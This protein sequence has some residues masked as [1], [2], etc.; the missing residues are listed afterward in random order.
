MLSNFTKW[1]I[2]NQEQS[3][4]FEQNFLCSNFP[5]WFYHHWQ[6]VLTMT[7]WRVGI[8]GLAKIFCWS[9]IIVSCAS[10]FLLEHIRANIFT[11]EHLLQ[12]WSFHNLK[13][14][15]LE[16][17]GLRYCNVQHKLSLSRL[18]NGAVIPL[19]L[20]LFLICHV[21]VMLEHPSGI[22]PG[23]P[24]VI[25]DPSLSHPVF[26]IFS[27]LYNPFTAKP[28]TRFHKSSDSFFIQRH[29]QWRSQSFKVILGSAM[30]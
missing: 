8:S 25:S 27:V 4:K 11:L 13:P 29:E 7:C 20:I 3:V 19:S 26:G 14:W 2:Q 15:D 24:S 17:A 5:L 9:M 10:S 28:T 23:S 18:C 30:D 21:Y 6:A 12:T 1:K 22:T 16:R